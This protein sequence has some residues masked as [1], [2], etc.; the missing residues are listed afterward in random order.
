MID[1][2]GSCIPPPLGI[3]D[4]VFGAWCLFIYVNN[5][6]E[7][8]INVIVKKSRRLMEVVYKKLKCG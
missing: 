2:L 7:L 4:C 8:I 3:Y 6:Y 5:I 1:I